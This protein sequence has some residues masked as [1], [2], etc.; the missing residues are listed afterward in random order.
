MRHKRGNEAIK[1]NYFPEQY[2]DTIICGDCLQMM[3]E[4]PEES[5][6][7]IV[8]D[9]PYGIGYQNQFAHTP[10]AVL[11]GDRGIDY[12]RFARESYR[13]LCMDSHAYF[14][15]RFDC[16]PYHFQ[17]LKAAGFA[18]KNCL[19]IEK[20]TRGGIGDLEGSFANNSEWLI[21]CQKGRRT[22]NHTALLQNRKKEG[23][24]FQKGRIPS[25]KYKT[26]F[27][28]CWFGAEYPKA[29]YHSG[30]QRS[31]AIFLLTRGSRLWRE[32]TQSFW[33]MCWPRFTPA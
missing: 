25:A 30:W 7:L 16:Y 10:H 31:G 6:S 28:S 17:C 13:I 3:K 8:T 19:V 18:G 27:P 1:M 11:A 29:T 21:F 20:G 4:L 15:T 9:P 12:E 23:T 14:F 5:V 32:P 2:R 22:F 33:P 24:Q 26:R